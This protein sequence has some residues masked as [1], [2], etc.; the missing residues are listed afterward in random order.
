MPRERILSALTNGPM[1]PQAAALKRVEVESIVDFLAPRANSVEL[2]ANRC[3]APPPPLDLN[4]PQWNGWGRTLENAHYQP[5]PGFTARDVGRLKVKWSFRYPQAGRA[6]AQPTVIGD[7]LYV[8]SQAGLVYSLDARTGCMY[9]SFATAGPVRTSIFIA[10]WKDSKETKAAA[11]FADGRKFVY[12]VDAQTGAPLWKTQIED[13]SAATITGSPAVYRDTIY[14]PVSSFEEGTSRNAKYECCTFRGSLVALDRF[15][16]HVR[17]KTYTVADA[18]KPYRKNEQGTQLLGPAGGAIWSAP[19]IDAKRGLIYVGT[20]NSYTD[21]EHDGSD[22]V[23]ALDLAS[24]SIKWRKQLM[25][26]DNFL[27]GCV[28][29]KLPNCPSPSGPDFDIGASPILHTMPNGKQVLLVGQ[30]SAQVHSMNPDDGT[31]F[32]TQKVGEG[33]PQGGVEW[34]HAA[35]ERYVYAPIADLRKNINVDG[36]KPGISAIEIATGKVVWTTP[37][38]DIKCA[39]ENDRDRCRAQEAASTVIPGVVF[40][41]AMDGHLRA[42]STKDGAIVWDFDTAIDYTP[43]NAPAAH[44]GPIDG[45]GATIVNGALYLNSG[46]GANQKNSG[47]VLLVF[48]VDGK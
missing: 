5:K 3:A 14:V 39:W 46:Y 47:N 19:T 13:H 42:Y 2:Q 24:G 16:G 30:K 15:D 26:D 36:G 34:G 23:L 41:P 8:T 38:P 25:K 45:G 22:A 17:W 6:N 10:P 21:V 7:R 12:A 27:V 1:Q 28:T 20:G 44:G 4:A 31:I 32:W 9:W 48:T 11:Y 18:P 37:T 40:S 29:E 43:V 33:G 35:D